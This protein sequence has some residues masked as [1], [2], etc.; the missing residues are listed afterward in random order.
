M[1]TTDAELT[2]AM[3]EAAE[4]DFMYAYET[5][6][7]PADRERLGITTSRIGGGVVLSMR[8]D[9]VA[10]WSKALG[11]GFAEPVT[12]ELVDR[13]VAFY[14]AQ[15]TPE[16]VI[17]IAPSVL[18]AEWDDIRAGYGI[19]PTT[20]WVKLAAP[21]AEVRPGRGTRLRVGPV[22]E[23]DAEEWADVLLRAFGMPTEGLAG[24]VVASVGHPQFHPYGVWDGA[25]LVGG[26]NLFVRGPVGALNSGAT[27]PSHRNLGVQSALIAARAEAARAAGCRWLIAETG[28]PA[29]GT[30]N[31]SLANLERAGLRVRYVRRNWRWRADADTP[32]DA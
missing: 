12:R 6:T 26:A 8:N 2:T 28:Q 20:S 18:P 31:Q 1:S 14:R 5:G 3:T 27:L 17:Q 22:G 9:P 24:M 7:P 4:A 25:D 23:S 16:A 15:G 21:I 13:I 29:E 30:K 11:F 10:Y 32:S 19:E